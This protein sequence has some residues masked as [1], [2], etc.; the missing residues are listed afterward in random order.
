MINHCQL[1]E[2]L[3]QIAGSRL[4]DLVFLAN[5]VCSSY[6]S[7]LEKFIVFLT[8]IQDFPVQGNA[9]QIFNNQR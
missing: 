4:N 2:L 3:K 8:P 7:T 6:R 9:C 1:T 5:A